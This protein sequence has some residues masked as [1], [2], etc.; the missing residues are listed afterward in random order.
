[1][2]FKKKLTLFTISA[3]DAVISAIS[4]FVLSY[5]IIR[6]FLQSSAINNYRYSVGEE[7]KVETMALLLGSLI[8]FIVVNIVCAIIKR[9]MLSSE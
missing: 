9:K 4:L 3:F 1:M 5:A 8:V 2:E 7:F 6:N